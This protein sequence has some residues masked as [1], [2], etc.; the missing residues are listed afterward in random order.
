MATKAEV[1]TVALVSG[2]TTTELLSENDAMEARSVP[3]DDV[4]SL[5]GPTQGLGPTQP[6]FESYLEYK[7]SHWLWLYFAP[8][9]IL[10]GGLSNILAVVVLR[11]H[12]FRGTG[13]TFLLTALAVADFTVLVTN[14]LRH[15]I[16]RLTDYETDIRNFTNAG[17]KTHMFLAYFVAHW[18]AWTLV[19]VTAERAVSVWMPLRARILCSQRRVVIVWLMLTAAVAAV[20]A[21]ILKYYELLTFRILFDD[22]TVYVYSSC[23]TR[24]DYVRETVLYWSDFAMLNAGPSLFI[25]FFNIFIVV[26]LTRPQVQRQNDKKSKKAVTSVT[27]MLFVVSVI[28]LVANTPATV[29]F[30]GVDTFFKTSNTDSYVFAKMLLTYTVCNLVAYVNNSINFLLYCLSGELFRRAVADMFCA[31]CVNAK[32]S[33]R[34][35]SKTNSTKLGTPWGTLQRSAAKSEVTPWPNKPATL[36]RKKINRAFQ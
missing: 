12:L 32:R 29:Y 10:G 3:Q 9:L 22:G 35:S 19:L 31:K 7:I 4:M 24:N 17:C 36:Q 34:S 5:Q 15:W 2:W 18:S 13:T 20:N 33:R 23:D 8:V 28:Y 14:V 16:L 27:V 25:F 30:L 11:S 26:K 21:P 1:S 6:G